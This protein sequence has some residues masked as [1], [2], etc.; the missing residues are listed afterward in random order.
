MELA[1][2]CGALRDWVGEYA[3]DLGRKD[4]LPV[5]ALRDL[6]LPLAREGSRRWLAGRGA[7]VKGLTPDVLDRLIEM[8]TDAASPARQ[9]FPGAVLVGRRGGKL[10]R[11]AG[12]GAS[13][14]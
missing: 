2:A 1:R 7:D 6:P 5:E 13:R 10:F 12:G 11:T 14:K 3:P 8:A 9:H 4:V